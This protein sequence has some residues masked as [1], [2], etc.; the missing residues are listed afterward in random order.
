MMRGLADRG[1]EIHILVPEGRTAISAS[2]AGFTVYTQPDL[3]VTPFKEVATLAGRLRK[4]RDYQVRPDVILAHHG[5]DH[6]WWGLIAGG[7]RKRIPLIRVRAQ[8]PRVPS[9]HPVALLLNHLRTDA[10][11]VACES[12][13]RA[14]VNHLRI[15]PQHIYRVPPG[16]DMSRW[17][18]DRNGDR[19]RELCEAG[20]DKLLVASIA[21]FAPQK[22]H[23]T[24]FSAAALVA[25]ASKSA[26]FLVAGYPAE[27][28]SSH[29]R[30]LAAAHPDLE[31]RWTFWDEQLPEGSELVRAADIGV[32]HS[33]GS[34]AICR[35]AFEYMAEGIPL[36]AARIGGLPEVI[37]EDK[38]GLSVPP[39]N[40]EAL[41]RAIGRLLLSTQLRKRLGKGGY[42]RLMQAFSY[43]R[44][45]DRLERKL[46]EILS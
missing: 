22:D 7:K 25:R 21:R 11:I 29:I 43:K 5:T 46:L 14:Y 31:G 28:K 23:A 30:E 36:I 44:A 12:Q 41:A 37:V 32:V 4:L 17:G 35:I 27:F 8:D 34:E 19:I 13:R 33:R 15:R 24:F 9:A 16:F 3:R 38:S 2:E 6:A 39:N 26:H 10:F 40:P 20:E 45:V 42:E 1:H 18:G